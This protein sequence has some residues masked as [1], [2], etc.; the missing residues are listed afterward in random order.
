M[1]R[2]L[3]TSKKPSQL[4]LKPQLLIG[5]WIGSGNEGV[6]NTE[7]YTAKNDLKISEFTENAQMNNL[8]KE[9]TT[10][11]LHLGI[12]ED[13]SKEEFLLVTN[14]IRE[15][16]SE[17]SVA[18]IKLAYNYALTGKLDVEIEA[19]GKFSP[20]YIAKILNAYKKFV[21][22]IYTNLT[23]QKRDWDRE[24]EK[25]K[26]EQDEKDRIENMPFAEKVESRK[27]S[28]I[29]YYDKIKNSY[30][31]LGDYGSVVWDF[32]TRNNL[33]NAD[34]I[35][36]D[37]AKE[38]AIAMRMRT[39][40]NVFKKVISL[41]TSEERQNEYDQLESMYGKFFVMQQVFKQVDDIRQWLDNF[42]DEQIIPQKK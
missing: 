26:I 38:Q 22:P 27:Q 19:Y 13:A 35:D 5:A 24:Q 15:N 10:W 25:K 41:M 18:E 36:F 39:T 11:R 16:Y 4:Q 28:I 7:I 23:Y 14:F 2:E 9:V 42:T 20:L 21:N 37:L 30:D 40:E 31:Y 17:L 6:R 1:S 33:I 34:V 32:L 3:A 12:R 8:L 29:W